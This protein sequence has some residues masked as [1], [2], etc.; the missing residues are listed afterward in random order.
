MLR[1]STKVRLFNILSLFFKSIALGT[2]SLLWWA[3]ILS[4]SPLLFTNRAAPACLRLSAFRSLFKLN[5][6]FQLSIIFITELI[7]SYYLCFYK[8]VRFILIYLN[9][10]ICKYISAYV[11]YCVSIFCPPSVFGRILTK[12]RL[13]Y[14]YLLSSA[15]KHRTRKPLMKMIF[16]KNYLKRLNYE[17]WICKTWLPALKKK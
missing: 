7:G 16:L 11:L 1:T 9:C 8:I 5:L 2:L 14:A 3:W 10:S 12:D 15:L 6:V 13:N 4:A 17:P